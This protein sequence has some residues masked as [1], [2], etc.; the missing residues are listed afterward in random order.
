MSRG[1]DLTGDV[2]G[3][4]GCLGHSFNILDAGRG[5]P[6]RS[7]APSGRAADRTGAGGHA[8]VLTRVE[9]RVGRRAHR[10]TGHRTGHGV[11]D[12]A[13]GE[14]GGERVSGEGDR[15]SDGAAHGA[16]RRAEGGALRVPLGA[17]ALEELDA[18][19]RGVHRRL[20]NR[21]ADHRV[22]G[23]PQDELD[24]D[25]DGGDLRRNQRGTVEGARQGDDLG[26]QPC[27]LRQ[28]HV[29]GVLDL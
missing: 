13:V 27:A 12:D 9:R 4:L 22:E 23:P 10:H 7:V 28:D 25:P 26:G 19:H 29:L 24:V 8:E 20:G 18:L 16:H 15:H 5:G 6:A 3:E 1:P 14:L 2:L 11:T 21:R 17:V